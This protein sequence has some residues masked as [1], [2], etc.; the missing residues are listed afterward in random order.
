MA[1]GDGEAKL[2]ARA[3]PAPAPAS[4]N[5][6][7]VSLWLRDCGPD[8]YS[9]YSAGFAEA[10]VVTMADLEA[11]SRSPGL[12]AE[13]LATLIRGGS[14]G[15]R[16]RAEVL[17]RAKIEALFCGRLETDGEKDGSAERSCDRFVRLG[18]PA[19]AEK[20][21][22]VAAVAVAA[23]RAR[24]DCEAEEETRQARAAFE[25]L[26]AAALQ[27]V[28]FAEAEA[29]S[30][31]EE[32]T[33]FLTS[34]GK[35]RDADAAAAALTKASKLSLPDVKRVR[36]V[37]AGAC[38]AVV[39]A[40]K[41][42][43]SSERVTEAGCAATRR[44]ADIADLGLI[45]GAVGACQVVTAALRCHAASEAVAR[46][47]CGAVIV[48]VDKCP[49][50]AKTLCA[51][52]VCEAAV[53]V[54]RAHAGIQ[55]VVLNGCKAVRSLAF[56]EDCRTRLVAAGACEAAVAALQSYSGD[57]DLA[58]WGCA[59]IATLAANS[60]AASTA[61]LLAAGACEAVTGAMRGH[62][63]NAEVSM[64]G[65]N[66]LTALVN[67]AEKSESASRHAAFVAA[68]IVVS[69]AL[70]MH[71]NADFIPS[72]LNAVR[73]LANRSTELSEELANVGICVSL[74]AAMRAHPRDATIARSSCQAVAAL[75]VRSNHLRQRLAASGVW[76]A[77]QAVIEDPSMPEDAK[78]EARAVFE[79]VGRVGDRN[80][81]SFINR[82]VAGVALPIE[83]S[84][85][86]FRACPTRV[87]NAEAAM[88]MLQEVARLTYSA[89]IP[90]ASA[91]QQVK[92]RLVEA[93]ACEAAVAAMRAHMGGVDIID[94]A[95]SS[96]SS[97]PS[98]HTQRMGAAGAC[99]AI[100]Q[101][102]R[103]HPASA[104]VAQSGLKVVMSLAYHAN[105]AANRKRLF[106][107]G[108]CDLLVATLESHRTH[109]GVVQRG[110]SV[111]SNLSA[112][113]AN[114]RARM[115]AA[116]ACPAVVAVM[117]AHEGRSEV[118]TECCRAVHLLAQEDDNNRAIL[119]AAGACEAVVATMRANMSN[120]EAVQQGMCAVAS[121]AEK[122]AEGSERLGAAGACE[123]VVAAIKQGMS[124]R[125]EVG[126]L[127][128][129]TLAAD[130][131]ANV[132][133]LGRA[134]ACQSV[135]EAMRSYPSNPTVT[136]QGCLALGRFSSSC[137]EGAAWLQ[138][139]TSGVKLPESI[140]QAL[141]LH[142]GSA[143]VT[144]QGYNVLSRLSSGG[145][146]APASAL[147]WGAVLAALRAH[148][149]SAGAAAQCCRVLA[150]VAR[151]VEA[152]QALGAGGGCEA[153]V[154]A[155]IAHKD[156]VAVAEHGCSA[157]FRLAFQHAGNSARLDAAGACEAVLATLRA[158]DGSDGVA[159]SGCSALT[160]L[161][162]YSPAR[163]AKLVSLGAREDCQAVLTLEGVFEEGRS[164]AR[165]A[166]GRLLSVS[167]P[168][169]AAPALT[170]AARAALL[171]ELRGSPSAHTLAATLSSAGKMRDA[172]A[173]AAA[174]EG[175]RVLARTEAGA[176]ALGTAGA[177]EAV[178]ATL[179]L[180]V[181]RE[182]S[183]K[184]GCG[185]VCNLSTLRSNGPRLVAAGA[186]EY[187]V[188][189]LRAHASCEAVAAQG[190]MA[191]FNL[192]HCGPSVAAAL[193]A[194]GASE[195]CQAV[196]DRCEMSVWTRLDASDALTLL[197]FVAESAVHPVLAKIRRV[198]TIKEAGDL[199]WSER[200]SNRDYNLYVAPA[201]DCEVAA[202]MLSKV[203]HLA[204]GDHSL[205]LW[206]FLFGR[207]S[208]AAALA[209]EAA[210]KHYLYDFVVQTMCLHADSADVTQQGCLAVAC[211]AAEAE[212]RRQLGEKGACG[213]VVAALLLH[214]GSD[215]AAQWACA[216]VAA[217]ALDSGANGA[218]KARLVAAGAV[219]ACQAV[220]D[221]G[222]AAEE[223]QTEARVALG[224]LR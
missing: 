131:A 168:T 76:A 207:A 146:S 128:V 23:E 114:D 188:A 141:S 46:A 104:V 132:D 186:C 148:A 15:E 64:W 62:A 140:A 120:T 145:G 99:E 103:E 192:A 159:R 172:E 210:L 48:L 214:A 211:L 220:L 90:S 51:E 5:D 63:S 55:S 65:C 160:W 147:D 45:L 111:I 200:R 57:G 13:L 176:N 12:L 109:A 177:C 2:S 102:I 144:E 164:A 24:L 38:E 70:A 224:R 117:R 122:S 19:R 215:G 209:A 180:Y 101:A 1:D 206:R 174:L 142:A 181:S 178:V 7:E 208:F 10:E 119:V 118:A 110:C 42:H 94:L 126:C 25:A 133:R 75:A 29:L 219:A 74:K 193:A 156:N 149:A 204:R 50:N 179:W 189:A 107:A 166:L 106:D 8:F 86:H 108:V 20:E 218:N 105:N 97:L 32:I 83:E 21:A 31:V 155:L 68:C 77:T 98:Q 37:N 9:K 157:I 190:C 96:L 18:A 87:A 72:S 14:I 212:C 22:A 191:L 92:S 216:A 198:R 171:A 169:A 205:A 47:G 30:T 53:A 89:S 33:A 121:L 40:M 195:A 60:A 88:S 165:A 113:D 73:A 129:A 56:S 61:R 26:T 115:G 137:A 116:G 152:R 125:A 161:A 34:Q 130:N 39:A 194:A 153:L 127:A 66:A 35:M 79:T 201:R 202:A 11:V 43:A 136:R 151:G 81:A 44:L 223:V 143:E 28:T 170:A 80:E 78:R 221:S 67:N 3:P 58:L 6:G 199:P 4:V 138:A 85:A 84:I 59:T 49:A 139:V 196:L 123:A 222:A 52:G 163:S 112:Y 173:A 91:L 82:L 154:Q 162:M 95:C 187:V 203:G 36:L 213:A 16:A 17:L 41:A 71:E 158:H 185:A 69:T 135:A 150:D 167:A 93:G 54:M 182:T 217:L 175:V 184:V 124:S 197:P 100:M 183:A 27:V 134:G